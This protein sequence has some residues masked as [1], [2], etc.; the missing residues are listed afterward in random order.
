VGQA[1]ISQNK[2][3]KTAAGS[4]LYIRVE[5]LDKVRGKSGMAQAQKGSPPTGA[6]ACCFAW[7]FFS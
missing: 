7:R 5:I 6:T 2:S 4:F 1:F 3:T